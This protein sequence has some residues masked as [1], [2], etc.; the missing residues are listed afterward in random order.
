MCIMPGV[1]TSNDRP[2]D[3]L[4]PLR[5]FLGC[6]LLVLSTCL[7]LASTAIT[8]SLTKEYGFSP[9]DDPFGDLLRAAVSFALIGLLIAGLAAGGLAL[10]TRPGSRVL[11][12][13]VAGVFTGAF[14]TLALGTMLGHKAL[15]A[16]CLG[17]ERSS[18]EACG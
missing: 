10:A 11:L 13:A 15:D 3:E 2:P 8:Y 12:L 14:V 4:N 6:L 16:R 7:L 18:T 1:A 9:N 5:R 17:P